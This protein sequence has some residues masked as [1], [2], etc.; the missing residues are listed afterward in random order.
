MNKN[1]IIAG[2]TGIALILAAV[3]VWPQYQKLQ[4]LNLNIE[5]KKAEFQSQEEYFVQ[6]KETS[7]KLQEYSDSLLKISSALPQ[8]P[9]LASVVSFLQSNS[10]QT[11][12]ILKKIVLSGAADQSENRGPFAE[13][14]LS[15]QVTGSYPAFKNFLTLVENSSRIIEV[16]KVSIEIPDEKSKELPA[17][18]LDLKTNSY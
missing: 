5:N 17:F 13:T 4:A 7:V 6:V 14:L 2:G 12:L 15:V 1:I 16:Q 10:A 18:T 8:D 9:A 3:F 11:G